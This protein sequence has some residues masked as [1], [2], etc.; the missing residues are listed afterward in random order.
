MTVG[1]LSFFPSSIL[2]HFFRYSST[3]AIY[4]HAVEFLFLLCFFFLKQ[5]IICLLSCVTGRPTDWHWLAQKGWPSPAWSWADTKT[6]LG[7]IHKSLHLFTLPTNQAFNLAHILQIDRT[8]TK[9]KEET[10]LISKH[11][12][13]CTIVVTRKYRSFAEKRT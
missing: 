11:T 3:R 6:R 9:D 2:S 12:D 10:I 13:T 5:N 7:R 1:A 8:K 4:W